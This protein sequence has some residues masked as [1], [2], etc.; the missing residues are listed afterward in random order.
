MLVEKITSR[1][2]PLVK[3]FRRVRLG[4][5]HHHIFIEGVRLVE[6]ALLSGVNFETVAFTPAVE[7]SERGARLIEELRQVRCRGAVVTPQVLE[8]IAETASPQ[9]IVAVVSRPHYEIADLFGNGVPLVVIA[10]GLQDPG[11]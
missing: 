10:D 1:Q 6:D 3:R 2:N 7:A 5:E 4:S 9:G 8:A 11:N